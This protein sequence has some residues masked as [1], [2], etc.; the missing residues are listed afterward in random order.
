MERPH[1]ARSVPRSQVQTQC[2]IL[3]ISR[4]VS[5]GS[6]HSYVLDCF[7]YSLRLLFSSSYLKLKV[8][9]FD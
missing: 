2:E 8:T 5:Y 6:Y 1:L 7:Y 3:A 4:F 9:P